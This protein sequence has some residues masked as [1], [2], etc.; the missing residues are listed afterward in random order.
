MDKTLLQEKLVG[1]QDSMY[2]FAFSLTRNSED[3][4]D[5]M[6]DTILK[7]LQQYQMFTVD[8][9]FSGWVLTIMRNLFINNYRKLSQQ[10]N[11]PECFSYIHKVE[12]NIRLYYSP[13]DL[14]DINQIMQAIGTL[15]PEYK[16][17]FSLYLSGYSYAEIAERQNIP[18]GTVKARIH[19][20]RRHLKKQLKEFQ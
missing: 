4:F 11:Y 18:L 16:T 9:H 20:A 12:N 1:L 15:I 8:Y 14:Y 3:A 10:K 19:M 7:V 17:T 6:Q 5:L 2:Y 13:D